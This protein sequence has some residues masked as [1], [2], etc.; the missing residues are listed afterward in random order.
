MSGMRG[1]CISLG[2]STMVLAR[3]LVCSRRDFARLQCLQ[4]PLLARHTSCGHSSAVWYGI[5]AVILQVPL[6]PVIQSQRA[7][8]AWI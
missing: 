2:Q 5:K 8:E 3:L 1:T 6:Q 7:Q 4:L